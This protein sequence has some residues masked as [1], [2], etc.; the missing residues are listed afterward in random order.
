MITSNDYMPFY[1]I[2][3]QRYMCWAEGDGFK[4]QFINLSETS[5]AIDFIKMFNKKIR[6]YAKRILTPLN[7]SNVFDV[8]EHYE[9]V[10]LVKDMLEGDFASIR[11]REIADIVENMNI[12]QKKM[13]MIED[14][15]IIR[16]YLEII[17]KKIEENS[18]ESEDIVDEEYN[19]DYACLCALSRFLEER[20]MLC[21]AFEQPF[22]CDFIKNILEYD[23][24]Q[25]M[26]VA[27]LG[28]P[29]QDPRNIITDMKD[30]MCIVCLDDCDRHVLL[31]KVSDTVLHSVCK[32]CYE[33][34]KKT[35]SFQ[36]CPIC[37]HQL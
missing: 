27:K 36:R 3:D 21:D 29:I 19:E 12:S 33:Q 7:I 10:Y 34:G 37:R 18:N 20:D 16:R 26:Y 9:M 11:D 32:S 5:Q 8:D 13:Y 22:I 14:Y 6:Q 1:K 35:K 2:F 31:H 15:E 24:E 30:K 25:N 4:Y 17:K 28:E 23:A